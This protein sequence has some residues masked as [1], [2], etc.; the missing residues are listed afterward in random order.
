MRCP[1]CETENIDGA[2]VCD[3]CNASLT[4]EPAAAASTPLEHRIAR[5]PLALLR[6]SPAV[7]VGPNDAVGEVIALMARRNFG[8]A[9][10]VQGDQLLGIFTE[11]DALMKIGVDIDPVGAEP[12]SRFMTP[13]PETLLFSD[14]IAFALNRMA[15]GDYRHIPIHREGRPLGIVSVRDVLAFLTREIPELLAEAPA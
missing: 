7:T 4:E 5:G 9:L 3:A 15:V 2:D 1:F 8:C 10:V 11:R 12:V 6:P 14:T 13:S